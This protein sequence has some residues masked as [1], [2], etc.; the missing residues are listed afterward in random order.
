MQEDLQTSLINTQDE[1]CQKFGFKTEMPP[2]ENWPSD[3]VKFMLAEEVEEIGYQLI[4]RFRED[5]RTYK[6]GYV[7]QQKASSKNG[8]AVLGKATT[9][10]DLQKCL[11]GYD[12]IVIIGHDTWLELSE[13]QKFRLVY[14]EL[15]HFLVDFEK[16]KISVIDHVVQEFPSVIKVFGPGCEADVAFIEAY[17]K[18]QEDNITLLK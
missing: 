18:F 15:E 9:Q 2:Q 16:D 8:N 5:L 12:A 11:H 10:A 17:K 4:N 6:I 14:H 7:F 13:D 3:D 1:I